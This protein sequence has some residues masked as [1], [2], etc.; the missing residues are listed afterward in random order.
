MQYCF[1]NKQVIVVKSEQAKNLLME[2]FPAGKKMERL[3]QIL[4]GS[5]VHFYHLTKHVAL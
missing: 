1:V 4:E 3:V 5:E 2:K